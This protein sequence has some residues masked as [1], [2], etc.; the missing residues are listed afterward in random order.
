MNETAKIGKPQT[1]ERERVVTGSDDREGQ[2][3]KFGAMRLDFVSPLV[4]CKKN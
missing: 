4:K 3:L 1:Q 2:Y